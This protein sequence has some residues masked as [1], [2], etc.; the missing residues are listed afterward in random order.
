MATIN[1]RAT[2]G[3]LRNAPEDGQK[4]EL[5]DGAIVVSPAGTRH[6]LVSVRL[7][8]RLGPFVEAHDLGYVV[9]SSTGFRLP[10][11]N[12][13]L[14]DVAFVA[15]GRFPDERVPE[16]FSDIPPDLAVEV[17]SPS[18]RPRF[19]LDKVGE[20]LQ[21]GVRLVWVIDPRRRRAAVYR[22]ATEVREVLEDGVLDGEDVVRGFACPLADLLG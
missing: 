22:S 20:Y 4:H 18:D 11:G 2:E 8:S 7:S 3:D 6:G 1:S 14:P 12:V 13:R 10:N 5:V 16:D 9:D 21:A 17:L 19:V 15:R